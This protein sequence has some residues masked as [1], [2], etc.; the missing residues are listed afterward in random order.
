MEVKAIHLGKKLLV[1][2]IQS[3][4]GLKPCLND[5]LTFEYSSDKYVVALKYGVCVFWGFNQGEINEFTS[6]ISP[7]LV[8]KF[9][10][11]QEEIIKVNVSEKDEIKS[12]EIGFKEITVERIGILSLVLSR[13]IALDFYDIEV[14]KALSE[15]EIVMKSFMEKGRTNQS[16]KRLIQKI[17]FAM[18]IRHQTVTQM[19][20]LDK[21]DLTWEDESLDKFYKRLAEYYELDDRYEVLDDKLETIFRNVEFISD[22]IT[23]RRTLFAE[24]VIILLIAFDLM[25]FFVEKFTS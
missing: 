16:S 10:N 9:N 14:E 7:Y 12:D 8:D 23:A 4:L 24:I 5:P 21:P 18:N 20:F 22:Y 15:N 6:L 11:P 13:S 17:G 3:S 2:E 1:R 19:A 25:I